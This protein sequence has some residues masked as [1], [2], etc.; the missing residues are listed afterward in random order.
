MFPE[1]FVY[2]SCVVWKILVFGVGT[3]TGVDTY[4]VDATDGFP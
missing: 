2:L 4:L 3:C 1:I